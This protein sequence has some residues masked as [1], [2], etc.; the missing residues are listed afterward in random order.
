MNINYFVDLDV[1]LF[2][3]IDDGNVYFFNDVGVKW[4]CV[5]VVFEGKVVFLIM[6]EFDLKCVYI[7]IEG[8]KYY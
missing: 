6:Y 3:D 1:V 5:D 4:E 7:F 2:Q 8:F